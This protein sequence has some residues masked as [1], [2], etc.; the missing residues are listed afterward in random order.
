MKIRDAN[1][2]ALRAKRVMTTVIGR[3]ACRKDGSKQDAAP[4]M[5]I[6]AVC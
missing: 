1:R 2:A 3:A 6:S 5:P 4:R